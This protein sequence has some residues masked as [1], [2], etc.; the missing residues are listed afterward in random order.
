MN[1]E[2]TRYKLPMVKGAES[3]EEMP[4][5]EAN[6]SIRG[7]VVDSMSDEVWTYEVPDRDGNPLRV[8]AR[9]RQGSEFTDMGPR[10]VREVYEQAATGSPVPEL[11]WLE[12]GEYEPPRPKR[13]PVKVGDTVSAMP[14]GYSLGKAEVTSVEW[15]Q[16]VMQSHYA[17]PPL[18]AW[19]WCVE[20][21][22]PDGRTREG[23]WHSDWISKA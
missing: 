18:W 12:R 8:V 20:V 21:T 7:T 13:Q 17:A 19:E 3:G 1:Y 14:D 2:V 10:T 15:K 11:D 6:I 22:F 4:G 5:T 9:T 23:R 16:R